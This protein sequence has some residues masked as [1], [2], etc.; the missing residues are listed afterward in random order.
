MDSKLMDNCKGCGVPL[1]DRLGNEIHSFESCPQRPPEFN[2][3]G[4]YFINVKDDGVRDLAVEEKKQQAKIAAENKRLREQ[5]CADV[6]EEKKD[7]VEILLGLIDSSRKSGDDKEGIP[8]GEEVPNDE[9]Q[10]DEPVDD[11]TA[12]ISM[13]P[14]PV[15]AGLEQFKAN[16]LTEENAKI[17]TL[18]NE[19]QAREL[20]EIERVKNEI[21]AKENVEVQR[22]KDET[23][24]KEFAETQRL[25]VKA[26][27]KAQK[28]AR[29]GFIKIKEVAAKASSRNPFI[30]LCDSGD[31][32]CGTPMSP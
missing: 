15:L 17:Q 16:L 32:S 3:S 6:D 4:N 27:L 11:S 25:L 5:M 14:A 13:L 12:D 26:V 22:I 24:A 19:L 29:R 8:D 20:E 31:E 10:K 28:E 2:N 9:E 30:D 1:R 23:K 7:W 21:R 18:R